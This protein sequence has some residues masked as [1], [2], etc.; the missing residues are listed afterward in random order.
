MNESGTLE[1]LSQDHGAIQRQEDDDVLAAAAL[2][3]GMVRGWRSVAEDVALLVIV[4]TLVSAFITSTFP[5]VAVLVLMYGPMA[6]A[7]FFWVRGVFIR[8]RAEKHFNKL[9]L[10]EK[11][12]INLVFER[13]SKKGETL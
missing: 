1:K 8:R 12:R 10:W 6:I 4:S 5:L 3:T 13:V 9:P 11:H 2:R 7:A